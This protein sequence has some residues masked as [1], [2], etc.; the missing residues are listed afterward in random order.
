MLDEKQKNIAVCRAAI[1]NGK[2]NERIATTT[3]PTK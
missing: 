3:N 2:E 1:R